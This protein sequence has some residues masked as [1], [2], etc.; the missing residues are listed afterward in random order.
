MGVVVDK[1]Y[2]THLL[3]QMF[4]MHKHLI[5]NTYLDMYW[6]YSLFIEDEKF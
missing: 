5:N 2:N 6:F 4:S 3:L 1:W